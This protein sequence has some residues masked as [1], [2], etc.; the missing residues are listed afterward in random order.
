M[1]HVI[2]AAC[3]L[4]FVETASAQDWSQWRGP[5]RNEPPGLHLPC[6]PRSTPRN[7][8]QHRATALVGEAR[9]PMSGRQRAKSGVGVVLG[10][11]LASW[12]LN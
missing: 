1:H 4:A 12:D 2:A 9:G 3:L 7:T 5:Q 11:A 10:D 6:R 8:G